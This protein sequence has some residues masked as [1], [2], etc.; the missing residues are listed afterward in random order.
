[1]NLIFHNGDKLYQEEN[2]MLNNC[3][4]FLQKV[5]GLKLYPYQE[6]TLNQIIKQN[7]S[8]FSIYGDDFKI[9]IIPTNII[10]HCVLTIKDYDE[11]QR[12]ESEITI[13]FTKDELDQFIN[14]LR[15]VKNKMR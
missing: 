11:N 13:D 10:G 7:L 14:L 6:A 2:K 15:I 3:S 5:I 12:F 8:D 1:M 4:V 9:E